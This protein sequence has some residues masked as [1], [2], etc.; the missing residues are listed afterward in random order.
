LQG[1]RIA[2]LF[3]RPKIKKLAAGGAPALQ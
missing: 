2:C 1:K 3:H